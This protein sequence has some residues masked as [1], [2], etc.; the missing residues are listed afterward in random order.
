LLAKDGAGRAL[1]A[2]GR[3]ARGCQAIAC[4]SPE[5]TGTVDESRGL[6]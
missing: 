6:A 1:G 4:R 2:G 3:M 5:Q